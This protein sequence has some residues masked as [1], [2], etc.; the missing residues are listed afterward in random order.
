MGLSI[1][2]L[3][4]L[5]AV[6]FVNKWRHLR[7]NNWPFFSSDLLAKGR[8]GLLIL[9]IAILA[10]PLQAMSGQDKQPKAIHPQD[11]GELISNGA[12]G[13]TRNSK[14]LDSVNLDVPLMPASIVKLLTG[15]TAF[16]Q[17]GANYR[18]KTEFFM[19]G[20]DHLYIKGYGDPFLVSEEIAAIMLALSKA[21]IRIIND[22]YIDQSSYQLESIGDGVGNSLNPYDVASSALAVNFN[23]INVVV[24]QDKSVQSGEPQTPLLPIMTRLGRDL[25]AGE[26]RINIS[27]DPADSLLLAGQLFRSFQRQA[28]INGEGLLA[29]RKAPPGKAVLVHYSSKKLPELIT[30]L[31]LYSNNFIANQIFLQIGAQN[32]GYPAT[33]QKGQQAMLDFIRKDPGLS[34]AAINLVEGSGLSRKNRLTGQAMLRILELFKPHAQLLPEKNNI[35]LK[36]GTLTGV[37]SYAGYFTANGNL[38]GFTIILNQDKNNRDEIMSILRK[39]YETAR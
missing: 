38:D 12:Y 33:W 13:V 25:P 1:R 28:G 32:F 19:D 8:I 31:M 18:F 37:Y 10:N 23:T 16:D 7:A 35:L 14:L 39:I 17:L 9:T 30:A 2:P 24:S 26:H 3:N 4:L 21:G 36:S 20:E 15:L 22:I 34:S 27:R 6:P 11:L 5:Q 29:R